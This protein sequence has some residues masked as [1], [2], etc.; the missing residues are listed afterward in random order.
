MKKKLRNY[1]TFK[2]LEKKQIQ[3]ERPEKCVHLNNY[4]ENRAWELVGEIKLKLKQGVQ[5]LKI[6]SKNST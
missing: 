6:E 5:I 1:S 3:T 2:N 4:I